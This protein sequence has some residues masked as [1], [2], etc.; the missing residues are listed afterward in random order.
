MCMFFVIYQ[1]KPSHGVSILMMLKILIPLKR[2]IKIAS[3]D[4]LIFYFYLSKMIR[5]D[6]SCES[7]A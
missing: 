6:F 4:I 5:L 2:Q 7:S 1:N 3:D